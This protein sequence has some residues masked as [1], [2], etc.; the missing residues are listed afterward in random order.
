MYNNEFSVA[1]K[2]HEVAKYWSSINFGSLS[3]TQL[4]VNRDFMNNLPKETAE[5]IRA[6][7]RKAEQAEIVKVA[8][9]D[10]AAA[11][12]ARKA[13]VTFVEFKDQ[14]KLEATLPD[15]LDMWAEQITKSGVTP[16]DAKRIVKLIREKT[17]KG[18]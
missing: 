5:A 15:T 13:G 7:G 10:E 1:R 6:A 11:N 8:A 12:T 18:N 16:G 3:G 17:G 9:S 14:D 4:F 2:L